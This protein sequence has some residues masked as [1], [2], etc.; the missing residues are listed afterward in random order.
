MSART[1]SARLKR[2]VSHGYFAPE[3]PSCF[4]ADDLAKYR[5]SI[6]AGIDALPL[7]RRGDPNHHTFLSEPAYFFFPR[8][9]REDRRH[10]V[11]N[12]IAHLLLSR[13]LAD[14]YVALRRYARRSKLTLTPPVFDWSGSR[15]LMRPSIDL[16]D[17]FRVNLSSRR[18]E[19]VVADVRAF[20][21]S[22]YTHAIPWAIHGKA[23]AKQNRSSS[24]LGNLIDLLCR[25]AQ[26]GQTLGL[27][28]GPDTSRLIAELVTSAIDLHLQSRLRIEGHDASRYIDDYTLSSPDGASGEELLA[29]LRQSAAMFELELNGEKSAI[30]PTSHRQNTGWQQEA[31]AHLPRVSLLGGRVET[32]ALQHF[33][34]LLGRMCPAHPDINVEKFGLQHARS[35]LVNANDWTSLQ[36]SLINAYRRNPSLISLLVEVCLLRQAAHAD[37]QVDILKEFIE[38]RIPV[39][40]RGNRTGEIIWLLFLAIRLR[41]TISARRLSALFSLENAPI[42][43]L[44]VYL[45]ARGHVHGNVDRTLWDRS[46]TSVGLRSPM[47]LYA[48]EAVTQG[49]LPGVSDGF[50]VQDSYF[51]LLRARHVQFLDIM[52]GYTSI[53]T[54]LRSLRRENTRLR[55]MREAIEDEDFEELDQLDEEEFEEDDADEY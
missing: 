32:S 34:Y 10:G 29:T 19:Y 17:N 14:N 50:I 39:L 55:R 36:F 51:S 25:N 37:V 6:L 23:F 4:V 42:A 26:D 24:H 15:A 41:L 31:R 13:V 44:V 7:T 3:L 9:G 38:H 8:F 43:L 45:D 40:A 16:R 11:P 1:K 5:K 53:S 18:E 48:Y 52:R 21:H 47:W 20:F 22:I 30:Y 27:P 2:L 35:A 46:L 28:V 54:T 12:P 49:L 33:L